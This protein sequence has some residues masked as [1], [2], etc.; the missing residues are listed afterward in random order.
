MI[1]SHPKVRVKAIDA[2]NGMLLEGFGIFA[3]IIYNNE[4]YLAKGP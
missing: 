2:A 4:Y 3:K 1:S